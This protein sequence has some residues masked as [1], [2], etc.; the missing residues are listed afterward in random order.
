MAAPE[1]YY[2]WS[3]GQD[4]ELTNC[5]L[6]E[7][8]RRHHLFDS[9]MSVLSDYANVLRCL[10]NPS[11]RS[12]SARLQN[13][14]AA[15]VWDVSEDD[16]KNMDDNELAD[17][18][19]RGTRDLFLPEVAPSLVVY[20]GSKRQPSLPSSSS[21]SGTLSFRSQDDIASDEAENPED[22]DIDNHPWAPNWD[23]REGPWPCSWG[24]HCRTVSATSQLVFLSGAYIIWPRQFKSESAQRQQQDSIHQHLG[25]TLFHE[26][27]HAARSKV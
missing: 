13:A 15:A 12:G 26:L 11:P 20:L 8:T 16:F 27:V 25:V 10:S 22:E 7:N 1:L 17:L 23:N 3:K 9:G 19:E 24:W 18:R 21:T 2:T 5:R 4:I 6:F 14:F